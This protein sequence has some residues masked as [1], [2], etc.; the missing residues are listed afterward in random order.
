[1]DDR[2]IT[3][4]KEIKYWKEHQL[5]PV[6]YC[7]YLLALYTNGQ[8]LDDDND[9]SKSRNLWSPIFIIHLILLVSMIPFS[10]LVVYITEF[11]SLLQLSIIIVFLFYSIGVYLYFRKYSHEFTLIALTVLLVLLLLLSVLISGLFTAN[12]MIHTSVIFIN[13]LL[14]LF[15]SN[16]KQIKILRIVCILSF[17]F[18]ISYIIF[19]NFTA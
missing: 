4:I 2:T 19:S 15:I 10:F 1:M 9:E 6:R 3:I 8:G 18:V 16:A 11:H 7:D 5:L 13:F 17:V 12:S 14:W